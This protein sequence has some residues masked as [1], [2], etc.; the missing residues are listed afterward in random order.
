MYQYKGMWRVIVTP[1]PGTECKQKECDLVRNVIKEI[2]SY[3]D[4]L[5]KNCQPL[6]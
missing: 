4:F 3:I 2:V 6:S 1:G 5:L